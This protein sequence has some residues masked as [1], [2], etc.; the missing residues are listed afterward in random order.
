MKW[1][2][3]PYDTDPG[4]D[5][6]LPDYEPVQEVLIEVDEIIDELAEVLIDE[7]ATHRRV[8]W[9]HYRGVAQ[10]VQLRL[11]EQ[12]KTAWHQRSTSQ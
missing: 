5:T 4:D 11:T 12:L 6:P 2:P 1:L 10:G 9:S 7:L 8:D 3:T